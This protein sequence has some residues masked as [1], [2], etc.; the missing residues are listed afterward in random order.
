[1]SIWI[2]RGDMT[3][4]V[5]TA[6]YNDCVIIEKQ[7]GYSKAK[8]YKPKRV[9]M[10]E[11]DET[12]QFYIVPYFTAKKYGFNTNNPYWRQIIFPYSMPDGT[13]KYLPEFSAKFRD[14]QLE[15]LPEILELLQQHNS[16]IIGLPPG[17]GKTIIAT[18][19]LWVLALLPIVIVKQD[20]V[21]DG[22]ITTFKKAMPHARVW[23]VG[24]NN[25]AEY[26]IILCMNERLHY[27]PDRVKQQVG[28]LII[29]E[30]HTLTSETQV[31]TFLGFQPKYI[32]FESATLEQSTLY[33][34][35]TVC[36]GKHGI[37]RVSKIP[38]YVF[39]VRTGIEGEEVR[40]NGTLVSSSVQKSLINNEIRKRI[41]QTIIYNHIEFRKFI[42][43]QRVT[44]CIEETVENIRNLGITA[45]SLYGTKKQYNQSQVL[46]GTFGKISTGFDEENACHDFYTNPEKSNTVLFINSIASKYVYEQSRG[47]GMRCTQNGTEAENIIP[48]VIC[49]ID[50]NDNVKKNFRKLLP[51]IAETNG[52]VVY[53]DYRH[54]FIQPTT[55]KYQPYYSP[56][57]YYRI[58]TNEEYT[59]LYEDGFYAG[60]AEERQKNIVTLYKLEVVM[61]IKNTYYASCK[62]YILTI[63]KCNLWQNG[64]TII[65]NNGM[66]YTKHPIFQKNIANVTLV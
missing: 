44:D 5:C 12:K 14:Y 63:H 51:W 29:D 52:T 61:Q 26:D 30:V 4:E 39:A 47:R 17:W 46:C 53:V 48:W 9:L 41:I 49:L 3:P 23:V 42:V 58:F 15:I 65:E 32:I 7:D 43:M 22:W 35:A 1:M 54:L 10:F 21:K 11:R 56:G 66:V 18:Y 57:M 64:N 50:E 45:D 6:I 37:F 20:K 25:P 2:N 33:E 36:S 24:E 34:M 28:T 55:I 13:T 16:V 59:S 27:V 60:N 31:M 38:H 19:L 62:C 40:K 8:G